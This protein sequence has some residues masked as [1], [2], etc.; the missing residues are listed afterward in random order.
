MAILLSHK[1]EGEGEGKGESGSEG[2]GEGAEG[3][4]EGKGE[5][6]F[7]RSRQL[8]AC[9][10]LSPLYVWFSFFTALPHKEERFLFVVYPLFA[11][12]AAVSTVRPCE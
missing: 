2:E 12:A 5:G 9:V 4:G 7:G 10:F 8:R 11:L 6:S 1:G 3:K